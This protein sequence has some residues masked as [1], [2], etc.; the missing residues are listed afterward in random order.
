LYTTGQNSEARRSAQSALWHIQQS[1]VRLMA[2]ILSFTAE[3]VWQVLGNG[4]DDSVMLHAWY[5]LPAVADAD[6]LAAKWSI[7]RGVRA[8]VA[9]ALEEQRMAGH[10][11]SALQAEVSIQAAGETFAALASLGDDLKFVFI[12][13]VVTVVES[14]ETTVTACP[15]VHQKCERC[16]HVREDVGTSTEHPELCGRCVSNLYGDGEER[17]H[18]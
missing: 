4:K 10:I 3:E 9:K 12:C 1:L 15:S 8:D 5:E 16:W 7:V 17:Q 14:A 6:A 18:A 11:G 13:S 2:P